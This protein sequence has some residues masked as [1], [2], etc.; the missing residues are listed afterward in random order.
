MPFEDGTPTPD[1]IER[2]KRVDAFIAA[3]ARR[4]I[5]SK[6]WD[7]Y[8]NW[9]DAHKFGAPALGIAL[10]VAIVIGLAKTCSMH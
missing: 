9:H 5:A 1:E 2:Q 6:A 7:A 8:W 10:V 3:E 4:S